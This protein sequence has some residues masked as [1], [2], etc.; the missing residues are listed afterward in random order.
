VLN[1][2][3]RFYENV[4]ADRQL[5]S[6]APRGVPPLVVSSDARVANLNADLLDG[7]DWGSPGSIGAA[8]P[9][10]GVFSSLATTGLRIG[11]GPEIRQFLSIQVPVDFAAWKSVGCQER[12]LPMS[13]ASEADSVVLGLPAS[14]SQLPAVQYTGF[15]S[16]A[17]SVTI[18]ACKATAGATSDPPPAMLRI[19]LWKH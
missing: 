3:A 14:L 1:T 7:R 15:V 18:R 2:D 10:T 12:I 19:D 17:G 13:G 6:N 9:A 5:Q 11:D 8:T 16:S 4:I